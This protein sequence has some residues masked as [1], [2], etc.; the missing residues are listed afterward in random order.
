MG[1]TCSSIL[2]SDH[3]YPTLLKEIPNPPKQLFCVGSLPP[4]D[5]MA[6]AIVGTRKATTQ[7]K[8]FAKKLSYDLA[9]R[10]I[11]V[12]SG[13]ALGIDTAA[14]EGAVKAGG[15]TFAVLANGLDTIYPSQN[16]TLADAIIREKGGIISEYPLHTPAFPNQFIARNRIIS[17][18]CTATIVIEAPERSGT[19][20]TARFALEQGREVFVVPGPV[21]HPNYAGSY[22]LVRDGAR[23][24]TSAEDVCEDLGITSSDQ[25]VSQHDRPQSPQECAVMAALTEAGIP[26][27]VDKIVELTT[28]EAREVNATLALLVMEGVVKET[29]CGYS[30]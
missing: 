22:K 9:S 26:L 24:I 11:V 30:I 1:R 17:G 28:M 21:D 6:I 12:V 27:L 7:G 8:L 19:L 29:E 25:S 15:I 14:H 10:G 18:L 4:P 23:L 2:L 13:L 20:A 16:N 3:R 5:M